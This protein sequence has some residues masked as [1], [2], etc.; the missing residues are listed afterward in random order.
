M[1]PKKHTE[2]RQAAAMSTLV[3]RADLDREAFG[4]GR[5]VRDN[6]QNI[7]ERVGAQLATETDP[8]VV[9]SILAEEV[10]RAVQWGAGQDQEEAPA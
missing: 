7:P 9:R 8:A 6:M 3:S 2:N 4:V 10:R 5:T 1:T